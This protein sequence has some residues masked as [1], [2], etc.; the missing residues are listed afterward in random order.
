MAQFHYFSLEEVYQFA[1]QKGYSREDVEIVDCG[2]EYEVAFGHEYSEVW[3]WSFESL[4]EV[5]YDYEH[6]VWE[7]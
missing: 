6:C 2:G 7:D 4:D 3:A 1:E 5:A